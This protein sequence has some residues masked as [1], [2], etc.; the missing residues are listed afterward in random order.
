MKKNSNLFFSTIRS[1]SPTNSSQ[2]SEL[3]SP[4]HKTN[5]P[6]LSPSI[7]SLSD[8][9]FETYIVTI[10][11][12]LSSSGLDVK[13]IE[14]HT[15]EEDIDNKLLALRITYLKRL[16]SGELQETDFLIQSLKKKNAELNLEKLNCKLSGYFK[17]KIEQ[18]LDTKMK[19]SR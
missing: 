15:H 13:Q 5:S 19:C 3:G 9:Y 12:D 2:P 7:F 10:I 8:D 18:Y 6:R 4:K 17:S 16:L 11:D 14:S 1:C